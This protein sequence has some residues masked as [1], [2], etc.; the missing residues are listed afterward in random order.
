MPSAT[1]G[2]PRL[3]LTIGDP[4]GIGPEVLLKCLDDE[5]LCQLFQ[6]LVVGSAAVME[7][8]A[9]ALGFGH[10]RFEPVD[11]VPHRG[12][13]P[14]PVLDVADYADL[15]IALGQVTAAAGRLSMQAVAQ[16]VDLCLDGQVAAMVTAPISKA[17]LQAAGYDVPGHTQFIARRAGQASYTMLMVSE[18]KH[19]RV[20]LLTDHV[21]LR[22]V[23]AHLTEAAVLE[24]IRMLD[25]SMRQDFGVTDPHIAVLG[26]N[27]HAGEGGML[28]QEEEEVVQPA[29][30]EARRQ[31]F[32]VSGPFPADGFFAARGHLRHDAVLAMYHD[33]GLVPFKALAFDS[34]VNFTAGLPLVRT[35]PD[36]GTAF[37]LAGKGLASPQSMKH[38]I[39]LALAIAQQR[40]AG[41]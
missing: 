15:S 31:G 29:L 30:L 17:A 16:A 4:N 38:A 22:A 1:P 37:D 11:R 3:A 5:A 40:G 35:S 10:L 8:Y 41:R 7:G 14:I 26:L 9:E 12:N 36:H 33:Q 19:L 25:A 6:P 39:R 34:G 28:G 21:P 18:S 20:G 13:G 2:R 32:Q 27:P 24:K 23:P